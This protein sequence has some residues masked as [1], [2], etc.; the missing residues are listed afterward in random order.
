MSTLPLADFRRAHEGKSNMR[1][2]MWTGSTLAAAGFLGL[3]TALPARA[4]D[5]FH[6]GGNRVDRVLLISIDGSMPSISPIAP[7]REPVPRW[8]G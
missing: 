3:I 6:H 2:A 4:D 7:P 5:G 8:R 1:G